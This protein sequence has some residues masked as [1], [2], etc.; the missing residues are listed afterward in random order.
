MGTPQR[1]W[2]TF[3]INNAKYTYSPGFVHVSSSCTVR[4]TAV[5]E[6]GSYGTQSETQTPFLRPLPMALKAP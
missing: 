2:D 5:R 6:D 3:N 4:R 1:N